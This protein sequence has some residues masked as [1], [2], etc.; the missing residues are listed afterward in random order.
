M[1]FP[2]QIRPFVNT[3]FQYIQLSRSLNASMK[4]PSLPRCSEAAMVPCASLPT[5]HSR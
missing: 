3:V 4:P 1:L 2:E 5:R